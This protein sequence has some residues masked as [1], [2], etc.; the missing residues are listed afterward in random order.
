MRADVCVGAL[1]RGFAG[2]VI[3]VLEVCDCHIIDWLGTEV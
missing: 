3:L 2:G 1:L